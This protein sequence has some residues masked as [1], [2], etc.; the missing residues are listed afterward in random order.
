M[1]FIVVLDFD[2]L[3]AGWPVANDERD[4]DVGIGVAEI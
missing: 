1:R 3:A 2:V 4:F